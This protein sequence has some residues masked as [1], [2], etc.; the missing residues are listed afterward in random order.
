MEAFHDILYYFAC[1]V[2]GMI[3]AEIIKEAIDLWRLKG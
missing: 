3:F 2:C 1:F